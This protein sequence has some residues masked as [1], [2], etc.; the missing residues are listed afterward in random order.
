MCF[1]S[2]WKDDVASSCLCQCWLNSC[3]KM[4][5]F[6]CDAHLYFEEEHSTLVVSNTKDFPVILQLN[7]AD[8]IWVLVRK[9]CGE[10]GLS[11]C[12]CSV[13]CWLAFL[14]LKFP[15][16]IWFSPCHCLLP[17]L[18][19]TA[20]LDK[21]SCFGHSYLTQDNFVM[22]RQNVLQFSV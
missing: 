12:V 7:K 18:L 4:Q 17:V 8:C 3:F 5:N 10:L 22:N 19:P 6:V 20:F 9:V 15:I 11:F 13:G 2:V 16:R 1:E 21:G 14:G